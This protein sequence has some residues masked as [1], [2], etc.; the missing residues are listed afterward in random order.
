MPIDINLMDQYEDFDDD[1]ELEEYVDTL[2]DQFIDSPE[3]Q[4]HLKSVEET[5]FWVRMLLDYGYRY[6]GFTPSQMD[7]DDMEYVLRDILPRKVSLS[8]REETEDAIPELKA[9]W[10]Y[11][12]REYALR[13]ADAIIQRLDEVAPRFADMMFDSSKFGMAKSFFMAGHDEGFDMTQ[14][15]DINRFMHLHNARMMQEV[16]QENSQAGGLGSGL[17]GLSR[18]LGGLFGPSDEESREPRRAKAKKNKR[19]IAKASR[20]KNRKKKK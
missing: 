3:G 7:A 10:H 19:K 2:I 6:E 8:S 17:G 9:F 14:E 20:K 5:G 4:E 15:E 11:L 13:Q 12:K 1:E 16:E 18:G